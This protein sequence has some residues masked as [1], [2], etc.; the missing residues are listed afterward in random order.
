[1]R[2]FFLSV[3][4]AILLAAGRVPAQTVARDSSAFVD[5]RQDG[6]GVAALREMIRVGFSEQSASSALTTI[7]AQARLNLT[8]DPRLPG[9]ETK[10]SIAAHDRSV[11]DALLEV[12]RAS[13]VL[14]RVSSRGQLV[15]VA[16]PRVVAI[17]RVVATDTMAIRSALLPAMR[18]ESKRSELRTFETTTNV[19]AI[20]VTGSA[21]RSTPTFVEPDVLRSI[22]L[23]PGIETRSD[24]TAGFNVHGGEADQ[25][26]VLIDGFPIYNPYHLGGLFS[27]FIDPMVGGVELRKGALPSQYGGRLSGALDVVSAE[28]TGDGLHGTVDVSLLSSIASIGDRFADGEGSWMFA[29]RRTYA[30]YVANLYQRDLFPYHFRDLQGHLTRN[31]PHGVRLAITA[32]DGVDIAKPTTDD[33]RARW[34][35]RVAGMSLGKTFD[36]T[37]RFGGLSFGDSATIEH[38]LSMSDFSAVFETPE[39]LSLTNHVTEARLAGSL[40]LYGSSST[41]TLGYELLAQRLGYHATSGFDDLGDLVPFDS[42]EQ[43]TTAA[44]AYVNHLWRARPNL[45]LEGGLRVDAVSAMGWAG[46]SPRLSAK[47]FVRPTL[48]LTAAGGAYTQWMHSLGREEEPFQPLQYWV[49]SDSLMPVSRA[50]DAVVGVEGWMTRSRLLHVEAFYKTYDDL[51]VPNVFNDPTKRGDEFLPTVGTSYGVDVLLRQLD[52]G[53]FSG[54]LAYTYAFNT[55]AGPDGKRYFPTQDRRHNLNAVGSWHCGAYTLGLRANVATGF[56]YTPLLGGFARDR[57]VVSS[58]QWLPAV[59]SIGDQNIPGERG[60]GRL[61]LYTRID[62]SASRTGRIHG[63]SV[64][65][66]LSIVNLLNAHNAAAYMYS[67]DAQPERSTLPNL[68]FAPTFGVKIAY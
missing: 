1:M 29:A 28:P 66:Y 60:S 4:A 3:A 63:A 42:L 35:N 2:R 39:L 61:P 55:R 34:G 9:L 51:L 65:P 16:A 18:T 59:T 41:T 10:I 53:S 12:A 27:T 68:P 22:Q 32:Y 54:W 13:H 57:Y 44:G 56:A 38:R 47:Y 8:F 58:H 26:L 25:S 11:A 40:A 15:V 7:A 62:V 43:R 17:P 21:L 20:T 33:F 30:D 14:V 67:F 64:T 48:A 37:P 23:L 52:G 19:G 45:L 31:F 24:Y 6:N 49:G 5:L 36:R 50:R 46:L